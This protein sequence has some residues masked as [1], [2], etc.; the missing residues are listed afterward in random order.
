MTHQIQMPDWYREDFYNRTR[1]PEEW[2]F[3]I[4]KRDRLN[5]DCLCFPF[6]MRIL[7][8]EE[9]EKRFLEV[10]Y[11][12]DMDGFVSELKAIPRQPT[13][14]LSVSDA[15]R[16]VAFIRNSE[17]FKTH[18]DRDLFEGAFQAMTNGELPTG[19][20]R[21]VFEYF[22]SIPWYSLHENSDEE[23]WDPNKYIS[24]LSGILISIDPNSTKND[25]AKQ[26]KIF[27][28]G[29]DNKNR[30][31]Y[32]QFGAW[33]K[34]NILGLFDLIMWFKL[35][36]I[37]HSKVAL[38]KLVWPEGRPSS[39]QKQT[40]NPHDDIDYCMKLI[41]SVININVAYALLRLCEQRKYIKLSGSK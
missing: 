5:M 38:H 36:N 18:P 23:E 37:N 33:R 22:Y 34:F 20:Q 24:H 31:I 1:T 14:A 25:I 2:L 28:A 13:K 3:E 27:L 11:L 39:T 4:W 6:S 19:E 17:L 35:K 16:V 32:Q 40:V 8:P 9:Q 26:L 10:I 12:D 41:N 15:F 7:P 30:D 21:R 29:W